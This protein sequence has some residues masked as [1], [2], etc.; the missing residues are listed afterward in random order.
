VRLQQQ[1]SGVKTYDVNT[2]G[3]AHYGLFA[4]WFRELALAADERA[5]DRGGAA[6]MLE[7]MLD[8]P[9]AYLQLWERGVYGGGDCV[10]DGSTLQQEDL[11]AALGRN[12]EGFLTA[13]GKPVSR[14]GAAYRYCVDDE[15]GDAGRLLVEVLF[16]D[17]GAASAVS[18]VGPAPVSLTGT[19]DGAAHAGHEHDGL[20][21]QQFH[22]DDAGATA[23]GAGTS[24]DGARVLAASSSPV[25]R[26]AAGLA[27]LAL[28]LVVAQ[29]LA[30]RLV[31]AGRRD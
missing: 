10:R 29:A 19:G 15:S 17:A 9:E 23:T 18:V 3:V 8:G 11:H 21:A 25:E 1:R 2:D 30:L 31:N 16:D 14:D 6:A 27:A 5:A 13:V 28:A 20:S 24:D 4:D 26:N 12:L 7:D 22:A